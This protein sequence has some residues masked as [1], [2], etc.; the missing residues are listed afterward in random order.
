MFSPPEGAELPGIGEPR[1]GSRFG[2]KMAKLLKNL[3]METCEPEV[4]VSL[5]RLPTMKTYT[6]L[7]KKLKSSGKEWMQGF[8]EIGGLEVRNICTT[9]SSNNSLAGHFL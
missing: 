1:Q 6:A 2:R 9:N 5:L 7:K 4:A 3:N 8:L